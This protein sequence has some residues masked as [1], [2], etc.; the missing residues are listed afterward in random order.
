MGQ[1]IIM[2]FT[3]MD[4]VGDSIEFYQ[5]LSI[6]RKMCACIYHFICLRMWLVTVIKSAMTIKMSNE[7]N[8]CEILW[9]SQLITS[10]FYDFIWC[11]FFLVRCV[12]VCRSPW[13]L[14]FIDFAEKTN[15]FQGRE[16]S[17][18]CICFEHAR[19][20][21]DNLF[22]WN[23]LYLIWF[24]HGKA[25]PR[26]VRMRMRVWLK[27]CFVF[28]SSLN[29]TYCRFL[30]SVRL[31]SF[32]FLSHRNLFFIFG[33]FLA[34]FVVADDVDVGIFG[35]FCLYVVLVGAHL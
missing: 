20:H 22:I 11:A 8:V 30:F 25:S 2:K 3:V 21:L 18:V 31:P 26:A 33:S 5:F 15:I 35:T 24:V 34:V 23:L 13:P 16:N 4:C 27:F 6:F 19:K 14:Y 1:Q 29:S 17:H 7:I 9:L 12:A 10:R 32:A 28:D